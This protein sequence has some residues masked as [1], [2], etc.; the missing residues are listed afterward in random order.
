MHE[1]VEEGDRLKALEHPA[2]VDEAELEEYEGLFDD[3]AEIVLQMGLVCM[4]SLG[5]YY[6]PLLAAL[7]I[8]LQMRVDACGLVCE[9]QHGRR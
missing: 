1:D 8:L 5:F 4:W 6:M 3:Y 2:F 9:P 7:E